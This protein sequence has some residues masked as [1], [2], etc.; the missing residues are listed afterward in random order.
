MYYMSPLASFRNPSNPTQN[1]QSR[2]RV[3]GLGLDPFAGP[4]GMRCSFGFGFLYVVLACSILRLRWNL[5][6]SQSGHPFTSGDREW[7]NGDRGDTSGDR[8]DTSGYSGWISRYSGYTG[9]NRGCT[10]VFRWTSLA[11]EP[12]EGAA[13]AAST[14]TSAGA[15]CL[16]SP[17]FSGNP[18]N[19]KP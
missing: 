8:G 12:P 11:T 13:A 15:R 2:H 9:G 18:L 17:P 6:V 16:A 14:G 19:P 4:T 1:L 10:I 5:G 7:T 3:E